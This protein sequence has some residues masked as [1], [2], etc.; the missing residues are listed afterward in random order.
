M[1]KMILPL[2]LFFS[3]ISNAQPKDSIAGQS[4]QP[5]TTLFQKVEIEAEFPGGDAAWIKYIQ[6]VLERN[7]DKLSRNKASVGTCEVQFIVDKDGSVTNVEALTMKKS[8][9]AKLLI[10]A[11][12]DGPRWKPAIQ[13]GKKVKAW[14]RQKVTFRAPE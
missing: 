6:G 4:Q 8:L 10:E 3:L 1:K 2:L 11:I 13:F 12:K 9:L 5:D 14:R 7:I